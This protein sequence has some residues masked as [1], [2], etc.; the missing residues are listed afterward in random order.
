MNKVERQTKYIVTSH[1]VEN[2]F[3]NIWN[4]I[5]VKLKMG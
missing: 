2:E 5:V 4:D 3:L 1:T